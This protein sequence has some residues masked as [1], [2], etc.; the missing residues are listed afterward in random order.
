MPFTE[1]Y[2][3]HYLWSFYID[4]EIEK[5]G[6]VAEIPEKYIERIAQLKNKYFDER[7]TF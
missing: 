3:W 5:R 4:F 2:L 7:H 6:C 1:K